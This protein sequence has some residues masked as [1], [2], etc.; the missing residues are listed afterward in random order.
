[1][2][3][4]DTSVPEG[5]EFARFDLDSVDDTA[6]LDLVVYRLDAAGDP[7]AGWASATGAADERVDLVAPEA[8]DYQVEVT[9][10][11]AN[12]TTA[13]DATVTSVLPAG[14]PLTLTPPVLP[15]VQ[16]VPS[17]FT[18]SWAGLTPNTTY[19]GLVRYGETGAFTVVQVE[20]GEAPAPDAPVNVSPP[21]ISGTP[22]PGKTLTASPGEWNTEG[23]TFGYQ[24]QSNGTDIVGATSST[25]RV[26]PADRGAVITVVVTA[27]AE[28]SAPGTATS[29]GVTVPYAST[30]KLSLN[31]HIG[32]S[33]QKVT[34]TITV[35]SGAPTPPVGTV[36]VTVN[37]K[38]TTV[39]ISAADNGRVTYTLP[40]LKTGIY[41]V[42][43]AFGGSAGVTGSRSGTSF[44]VILF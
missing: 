7:V 19:L 36:T 20:T 6:D 8:G 24:W 21:V 37:G 22:Q 11:A 26:T 30:T 10:Y 39:P 17:T 16:G 35:T 44:V 5:A 41:V 18:A 38:A 23:L 2:V 13:W 31:R 3:T 40:K 33:W 27:T 14:S 32:F 34:A 29:A 12:P 15:G 43:A 9:V 28:G 25:Y 42:S 4:Y 1:V